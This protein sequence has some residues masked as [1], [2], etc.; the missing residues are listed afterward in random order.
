ME[1]YIKVL[2]SDILNIFFIKEKI[3]IEAITHII[4]RAGR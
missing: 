1:N 2:L 3:K 4:G